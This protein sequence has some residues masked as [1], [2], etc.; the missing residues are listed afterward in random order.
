M[1]GMRG[2]FALLCEEEEGG[3]G[4]SSGGVPVTRLMEAASTEPGIPMPVNTEFVRVLA[5]ERRKII[6]NDKLSSKEKLAL[7]DDNRKAMVVANGG[8]VKR[9]ENVVYG[10]LVFGGVLLVILALLTTFAGLPHEV[11]LSF[12]GTVLGGTIATIA[13]KLGNL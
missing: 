13:Q 1:D 11:T 9:T 4:S 3:F 12:V 5:E 2:L 6:D 7:L 10:I 8:T